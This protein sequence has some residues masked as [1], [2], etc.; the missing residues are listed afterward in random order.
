MSPSFDELVDPPGA[1]T[2]V[3]SAASYPGLR[4]KGGGDMAGEHLAS[5]AWE[6]KKMPYAVVEGT[7]ELSDGTLSFTPA[8]EKHSGWSVGCGDVTDV[9]RGS[10]GTAL[11]FH[12]SGKRYRVAFA[13][14]GKEVL[15]LPEA[16]GA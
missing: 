3:T 10:F 4:T 15:V 8:G 14:P 2:R 7:L 13:A 1:R 12:A 11:K 16:E 5:R 9:S 6:T